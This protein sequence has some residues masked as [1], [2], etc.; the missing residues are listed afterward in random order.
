MDPITTALVAALQKLSEPAIR[1]AYTGLKA[2]IARKFGSSSRVAAAVAEVE[3][4][5]A[6]TGR[7]TVLAEEV[8]AARA[9][10]DDE[11]RAA[12][13]R[14]EALLASAA[15]GGGDVLTQ[16]I[17]GSGNYVVGKGELNVA[18]G[19]MPEP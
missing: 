6:S 3:A 17:S 13:Q 15:P 11:I 19:R 4:Q 1:D 12:V 9:G 7:A 5:P 18:H 14:L 10:D 16:T 2:L 8:D